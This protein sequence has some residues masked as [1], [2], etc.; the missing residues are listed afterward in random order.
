MHTR[1]VGKAQNY[2]ISK[3]RLKMWLKIWN[4]IF[5]T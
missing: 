4:M 2:N 3:L 1:N 5:S